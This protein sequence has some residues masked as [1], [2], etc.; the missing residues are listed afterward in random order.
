MALTLRDRVKET[1][2]TTGTGT[3]TL[4]GAVAG[5]QSFSAV[6]NGNT[7]YYAIVGDTEWEVGVGTYTSSGTTLSRDTILSSSNSGSA[8]S[9]S[10]GEKEVFVTL[11][12]EKSTASGAFITYKYTATSGQTVFSGADDDSNSLAINN[13]DSVIV[14]LNG[15]TLENGT[16]YTAAASSVTL[17][18]GATVN[19]EV[20]IYA[21]N[22]FE[23]ATYTQFPF[24]KASGGASNIDLTGFNSIRFFKSDGSASNIALG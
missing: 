9:F 21:F 18:S 1:T 17:T 19:D 7:T 12:A 16:D 20:N 24:Y 2:T 3:I 5:F 14:T 4:A 23:V 11:P 10:A 13:T 6:G 15:V 22:I 8:V